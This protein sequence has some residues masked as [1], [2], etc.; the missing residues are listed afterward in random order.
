MEDAPDDLYRDIA[1]RQMAR[2]DR[3]AKLKF[4][5]DARMRASEQRTGRSVERPFDPRWLRDVQRVPP[6]QP[7][8][9]DRPEPTDRVFADQR[10]PRVLTDQEPAPGQPTTDDRQSATT[11]DRVARDFS[12]SLEDALK[13]FTGA[14]GGERE[15]VVE[16]MRELLPSTIEVKLEHVLKTEVG[17]A[18]IEQ[19]RSAVASGRENVLQEVRRILRERDDEE[20][21]GGAEA[22]GTL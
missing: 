4:D 9:P 18:V 5:M 13:R 1:K 20:R 3:L 16:R 22:D 10:P 11:I 8:R 19:V 7:V 21:A 14:T 12:T 17:E 2:K 6:A 15:D